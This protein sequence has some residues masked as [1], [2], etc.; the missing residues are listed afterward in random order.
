MKS[1]SLWQ[2]WA[3]LVALGIKTVE[4]R[5]WAT[6]YR[7]PL[8]IHAATHRP[9]M[10]HL[11]PLSHTDRDKR[12]W[13]VIDTITAPEHQ[14]PHRTDIR[15]RVP[16][17]ATSPTLMFPH[18]GSYPLSPEGHTPSLVLPLGA[19]VATCELVDVVPMVGWDNVNHGHNKYLRIGMT[20]GDLIISNNASGRFMDVTAQKPYGDFAPG[21][22]AWLLNKI[23]PLP[24][25]IPT[26]G[27]QGLWNW[28]EET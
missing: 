20:E 8:A 10:M 24:E 25:P 7:G 15:D 17:W 3:S 9:P 4:T 27:R 18:D 12:C 26:R 19:V 1:L 11:P 16:K 28:E 21:R 5:S 14:R 23:K 2:P 13:L 22:F 6:S